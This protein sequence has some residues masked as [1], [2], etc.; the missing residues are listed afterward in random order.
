MMVYQPFQYNCARRIILTVST[1]ASA[2]FKLQGHI[3]GK[4]FTSFTSISSRSCSLRLQPCTRPKFYS[5]K[6]FTLSKQDYFSNDI[7]SILLKSNEN[8]VQ[9]SDSMNKNKK[10]KAKPPKKK[11]QNPR[12]YNTISKEVIKQNDK[13]EKKKNYKDKSKIKEKRILR[14]DRILSNRGLGSRSEMHDLVK[15]QRVAIQDEKTG[16]ITV[17]K[18]PSVSSLNND[19]VTKRNHD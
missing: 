17:V 5:Q 8:N 12:R 15:K 9:E 16:K 11:K 2:S 7:Q 10:D 1:L 6:S 18:G 14:I 4:A 13:E 19:M 3:V